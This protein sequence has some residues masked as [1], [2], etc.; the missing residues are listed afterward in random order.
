M[1]FIGVGIIGGITYG[2]KAK[3][4]IGY[5]WAESAE[6]ITDRSGIL[7]SFSKVFYSGKR[8]EGDYIVYTKNYRKEIFL[9]VV[10]IAGI[11]LVSILL[12]SPAN[13]ILNYLFGFAL[14]ITIYPMASRSWGAKNKKVVKL[15][16]GIQEWWYEITPK[17]S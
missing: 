14:F 1:F 7:T 6:S 5:G 15:P 12:P 13:T 3:H 8:R 9:L 4:E 2:A 16:N 17:K 11:Y 10:W